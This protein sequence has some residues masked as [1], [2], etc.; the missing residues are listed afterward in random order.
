MLVLFVRVIILYLL[1]FFVIRLS[2][3][4]QISELQPFDLCITLLIADMASV[5]ATNTG[6]PLLY[7]VVPILALFLLQQFIAVLSL[8]SEA[9]RKAVCGQPVLLIARGVVQEQAL[10]GSRYTLTDLMEQLRSKDVFLMGDV[11]YAILETNGELSVLLKGPR[12]QPTYEDFAMASPQAAPP[13]M[14]I[15]DGSLHAEA[16]KRAGKNLNWLQ[17]QL[18]RANC[19]GVEEV[20][21][22]FLA[23]DGMLHLQCKA[24]RGGRSMF[25]D[26]ANGKEHGA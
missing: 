12:Q 2:G 14:L 25:L 24:E 6:V 15:Q 23:P 11:E 18:V 13:L 17:K 7:G 4:R 10:K 20:F 8:K 19:G 16:L 5:P 9:V 3:K 22:A 1:V 21:F 26:T